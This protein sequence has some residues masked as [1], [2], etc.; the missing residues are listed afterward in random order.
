MVGP[1]IGTA[2]DEK[3][4]PTDESDD[5]SNGRNPIRGG[6][7]ALGALHTVLGIALYAVLSR[8]AQESR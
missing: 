1:P 5:K 4:Q 3:R 7:P 2:C 8:A 6:A